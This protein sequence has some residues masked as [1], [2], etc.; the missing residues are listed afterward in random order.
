MSSDMLSILQNAFFTILGGLISGLIGLFIEDKRRKNEKREK[1]F[2]EIKEQCLKPLRDE[3]L[4]LHD[5]FE[6]GE[7]KIPDI[8]SMEETLESGI[9]WW[10]YY[11]IKTWCDKI[12]FEDL[13]NHF[14]DLAKNLEEVEKRIRHEYPEFYKN[15]LNL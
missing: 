15:I 14:S 11:S 7:S 10:D 4:Y 12:L 6:F 2:Q 9:H 1:H 5:M 8:H 13:R 3:L